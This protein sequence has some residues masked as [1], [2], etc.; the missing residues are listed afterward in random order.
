MGVS[1]ESCHMKNKNKTNMKKK[2][3][4]VKKKVSTGKLGDIKAFTVLS[5]SKRKLNYIDDEEELFRSVLIANTMKCVKQEMSSLGASKSRKKS[6]DK[7][8]KQVKNRI[9]LLG[10]HS[11]TRLKI[12]RRKFS[13]LLKANGE[14]KL[15]RFKS[16]E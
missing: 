10:T 16:T 5:L 12:W 11:R 7:T 13:K 1:S 4:K 3:K 2:E 15:K 6:R 14:K 9:N 8:V